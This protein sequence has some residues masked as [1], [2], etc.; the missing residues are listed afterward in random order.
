[1]R[2]VVPF[3]AEQPKTRL[4]DVFT[5]AERREFARVM[6]DDVL[7]ALREAGHTPEVLTTAG[8]DVDAP[9]IVDDRPLST[10]VDAVL[11]AGTPVAVVMADLPLATPDALTRLFAPDADVVLAPGRG[12]GTNAF[13][14]RHPEFRVDY[15]GASYRDHRERAREVGASL[16]TVDSHRLATDVDESADLAEVLLHGTGETRRW[17]ERQDVRLD[18]SGDDRVDIRRDGTTAVQRDEGPETG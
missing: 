2:V 5:P 15:H 14:T 9:T 13:V 4:A 1:M 18:T 6:L 7:R 16:A 8:I 3:A 10:A 17:L 11:A 12:G